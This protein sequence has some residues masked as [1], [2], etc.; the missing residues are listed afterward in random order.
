M[1]TV[2]LIEQPDLE[3][4]DESGRNWTA[5]RRREPLVAKQIVI[6]RLAGLGDGGLMAWQ[7]ITGLAVR[8]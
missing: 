8:G 2:G 4:M 1:I 7:D 5:V 6:P 3:Q